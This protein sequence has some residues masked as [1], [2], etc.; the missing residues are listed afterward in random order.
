MEKKVVPITMPGIH[1]TFYPYLV[2]EL[3]AFDNP[4]ILEIGSGHGAFTQRLWED[5]YDVTASDLYPENFFFDQ[6]SCH[7]VDLRE[8][9]PFDAASFDMVIAVEV[10]EH[11]HDHEMFFRE[12]GRILKKGGRL[13][14]STPNIL[15]L[16]SRIR[17]LFSGFFYT[18]KALDHQ[19]NDGLQHVSSLTI[20]QYEN[21]GLRNGLKLADIS[22]D[23]LQ[24][25]S[26][27]YFI[28]L[29]PVI[30][31]YCLIKKIDS[32]IHNKRL[33][34]LGRILFMNF[35]KN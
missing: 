30:R 6:L 16:K 24:N 18:F 25:T 26:L 32:S 35:M 21:L 9:M 10:M 29:Y 13:I 15:S 7:K 17:F 2:K 23:K 33:H 8:D 19:R 20:N 4:K 3:K 34:L 22:I 1:E 28:P 31:I 12:C 27:I 5:G 14:F 11:V